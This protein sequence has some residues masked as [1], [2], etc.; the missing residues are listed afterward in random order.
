MAKQRF[1][2]FISALTAL[3]EAQQY[4]PH[5]NLPFTVESNGEGT[6]EDG[7]AGEQHV[8]VSTT[9]G[10]RLGTLHEAT[11]DNVTS[12]TYAVASLPEATGDSP[13]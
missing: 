8:V 13:Q 3:V 2:T 1:L 4:A 11:I 10:T 12:Y 6:D 7:H 9:Q 5:T